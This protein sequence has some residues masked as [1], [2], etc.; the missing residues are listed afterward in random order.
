MVESEKGQVMTDSDLDPLSNVPRDDELPEHLQLGAHF[1][2]RVTLLQASGIAA[3]Y[4]DVFC[5]FKWVSLCIVLRA[6][7]C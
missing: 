5:Q 1:T 3:D 6:T 4:T 2:F 7:V